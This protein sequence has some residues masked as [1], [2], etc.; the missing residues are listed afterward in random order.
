MDTAGYLKS[1]GWLG[2]GHTLSAGKGLSKPLL[3]SQKLDVLGLGKKRHNYADQW[4]TRA[5]DNSLEGLEVQQG[6]ISADGTR[7][8]TVMQ[9]EKG[10]LLESLVGGKGALYSMFVKGEGLVGTIGKEVVEEGRIKERELE[11]CIGSRKGSKGERRKRKKGKSPRTMDGK[12][13]P[14]GSELKR[15][16]RRR[17]LEARAS[18]HSK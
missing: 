2:A 3:V 10:G 4:W 18:K 15:E 17:R 6:D 7:E 8:V 11:E 5:F 1:Q 14:E 12:G 13:S 16:R 9:T